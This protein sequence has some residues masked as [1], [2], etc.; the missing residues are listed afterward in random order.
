MMIWKNN[1][2]NQ[3]SENVINLL[4]RSCKAYDLL[5]MQL[6]LYMKKKFLVQQ[7][8]NMNVLPDAL[9]AP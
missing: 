8:G 4:Y 3:I 9:L 6:P 7:M 5:V 1:A 2:S